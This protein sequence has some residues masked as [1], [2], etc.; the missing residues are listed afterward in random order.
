MFY[1]IMNSLALISLC[2]GIFFNVQ[3]NVSRGEDAMGYAI[4]TF[5][6]YGAVAA[7][8]SLEAIVYGLSKLF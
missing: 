6:C 7:C 5:L 2:G 3:A 1:S 4:A 8:L